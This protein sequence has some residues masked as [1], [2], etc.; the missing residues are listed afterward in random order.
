MI[1][2]FRS[3][4]ESSN[5]YAYFIDGKI[6]YPESGIFNWQTAKQFTGVKDVDDVEIYDGDTVEITYKNK[7]HAHHYK[8]HTNVVEWG[9]YG[10][11]EY[12]DNIECWMVNGIPLSDDGGMYGEPQHT[13]KLL[14]RR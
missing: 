3:Y 7:T 4:I 11:G 13:K 14:I 5:E 9:S 1:V 12:I 2:K 6:T 8:P 10:D